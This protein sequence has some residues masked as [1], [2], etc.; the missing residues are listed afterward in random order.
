MKTKQETVSSRTIYSVCQN[1]WKGLEINRR[2][3][4][5]KLVELTY[6]IRKSGAVFFCNICLH[7]PRESSKGFHKFS[8]VSWQNIKRKFK[9]DDVKFI[10]KSKYMKAH[11]YTLSSIRAHTTDT[12]YAYKR[13]HFN[14]TIT[15]LR[16]SQHL[17]Q[18][19]RFSIVVKFCVR[20]DAFDTNWTGR[21]LVNCTNQRTRGWS[22]FTVD[23]FKLINMRVILDVKRLPFIHVWSLS[24]Y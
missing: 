11:F 21:V 7:E 16:R 9:N 14:L 17:V 6:C 10:V 1:W 13:L 4:F 18:G 24:V 19:S 15:N 8:L 20:S 2:L 22:K 3:E 12:A 23:R 5:I